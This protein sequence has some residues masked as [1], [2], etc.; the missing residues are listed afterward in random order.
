MDLYASCIEEPAIE[1]K[2]KAISK[3][4]TKDKT[5]WKPKLSPF[6]YHISHQVCTS[7]NS[8]GLCWPPIIE[9]PDFK[10]PGEETA[11]LKA[12]LLSIEEQQESLLDRFQ[13]HRHF[14][15][16]STLTRCLDDSEIRE[17]DDKLFQRLLAE[18]RVLASSM[19]KG[20]RR[21]LQIKAFWDNVRG[22]LKIDE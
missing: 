5:A 11:W 16:T 20:H 10:D 6:W 17:F 9:T 3:Y 1:N 18:T 12:N 15:E 22:Q 7:T 13:R 8:V 2:N 19:L 14:F 21:E 4:A